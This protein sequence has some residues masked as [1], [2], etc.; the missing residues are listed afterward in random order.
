LLVVV[1]R[2][3]RRRLLTGDQTHRLHTHLQTFVPLEKKEGGAQNRKDRTRHTHTS[4]ITSQPPSQG[5]ANLPFAMAWPRG[6]TQ[7]TLTV[8]TRM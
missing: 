2:D 6:A 8:Y 4:N 3:D 7:R 1:R 5:S